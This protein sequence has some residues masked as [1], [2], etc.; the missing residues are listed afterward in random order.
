MALCCVCCDFGGWNNYCCYLDWNINE[1]FLRLQ[2]FCFYFSCF[3]NSVCA[4][5]NL[6]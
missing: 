4:L 5:L 2:K 3:I 1:L 6:T